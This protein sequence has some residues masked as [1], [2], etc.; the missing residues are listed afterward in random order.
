MVLFKV[1]T[2]T[3]EQEVVQ[4]RWEWDFRVPEIESSVFVLPQRFVKNKEARL[5]VLNEVARS[6]IEEVRGV[7]PERVFTYRGQPVGRMYDSA[8]KRARDK[9]ALPTFARARLE[10][11]SR[12]WIASSRCELRGRRRSSF[13]PFHGVGEPPAVMLERRRHNGATRS[14]RSRS[15]VRSPFQRK[16]S[17]HLTRAGGLMALPDSPASAPARR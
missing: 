15:I 13:H 14:N 6:V 1:N 10:T 12:S 2:G 17:D 8:W 3:R 16:C 7:H 4:L 11:H 5:I 9:A